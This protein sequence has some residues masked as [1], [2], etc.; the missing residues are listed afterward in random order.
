[1]YSNCCLLKARCTPQCSFKNFSV[2]SGGTRSAN[3]NLDSFRAIRS[4]N[5]QFLPNL[6]PKMNRLGG[7]KSTMYIAHTYG[8][9]GNVS[10]SFKIQMECPWMSDDSDWPSPYL[11][12]AELVTKPLKSG[13]T[14]WSH[15]FNCVEKSMYCYLLLFLGI[16]WKIMLLVCHVTPAT[17]P[18]QGCHNYHNKIALVIPVWR[19][20]IKHERN[21]LNTS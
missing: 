18:H 8:I 12:N 11:H 3:C 16:L 17:C 20:Q 15:G 6:H 7:G 13:F 14:A 5:Y 19:R 21:I 4:E 2:V 10:K 9:R 1:M